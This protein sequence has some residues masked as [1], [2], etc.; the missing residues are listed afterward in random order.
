ME[1]LIKTH[2]TIK[3][4]ITIFKNYINK[5]I[6]SSPDTT[7]TLNEIKKLEIKERL[8]RIREV[9]YKFDEIQLQID[10]LSFDEQ[11]TVQYRENFEEEYFHI[12][13]QAERLL[14][15][16]DA[17]REPLG[18]ANF[19]D[20]G[21]VLRLRM[22]FIQ[23]QNNI[24]NQFNIPRQANQNIVFKTPGM[25]LSTIELPKF[26][27]DIAEWLGFRDTFE[28]LIHN[29]ETIDP[30]QKFHYLKVSLENNAAQIIKSLEFSA[31]NYTVA[32]ET[33]CSRF[34][35]KRLLTHNH[36][37]A[38]FSISHMQEESSTRI[39]DIIDTLNKHIR[40]LNALGQ[41]TEHW[42]AL[43]IYLI[44]DKIDNITAREWERQCAE[45]ELLTL[46]E[47]KDFLSQR[48]NLLET[49]ELN[50]KGTH[51]SKRIERTKSKSFLV[52]KKG[53]DSDSDED[54]G[55]NKKAPGSTAK[56]DDGGKGKGGGYTRAITLSPELAAVVGAKQMARHEVVKKVWSII[57]ERNLYD[58]KN[59][60]FAICDEELMKIIG[61][62][63]FRPFGMMKYLRNNFVD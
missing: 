28:S 56:K 41:S 7:Q 18:A 54:W 38:I 16:G 47:F 44:S 63:R 30:I 55:K 25:R 17:I 22:P 31:I 5:V 50:N 26:K 20:Q 12:V 53:S 35:N 19:E 15:R 60:Q 48:A 40:A 9:Y 29:N 57:E 32:W 58:P 59:K 13:A 1:A 43:L 21:T 62:K 8:N 37:K 24:P 6:A 10:E 45:N 49:L 27:G 52:Q 46:E 39:R 4:K 14:I 42:D 51:N 2:G 23:E 11:E 36:I 61:V 34:D 33:I 3:G